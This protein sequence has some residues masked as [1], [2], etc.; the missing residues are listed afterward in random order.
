MNSIPTGTRT[1]NRGWFQTTD[2]KLAAFLWTIGCKPTKPPLKKRY[3]AEAPDKIICKWSFELEPS[4][5]GKSLD[6]C[7]GIWKK[8]LAY[9][10]ENPDC[11]IA[12]VMATIKNYAFLVDMIEEDTPFNTLVTY[13][14][15]GQTFRVLKD[16]KKHKKLQEKLGY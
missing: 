14:V 16:S 15:N 13:D 4:N 6:E 2:T 8:G 9:F 3:K 12:K 10:A 7:V 11:P 5:S 1:L